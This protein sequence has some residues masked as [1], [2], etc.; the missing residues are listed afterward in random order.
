MSDRNLILEIDD[1]VQDNPRNM[2]VHTPGKGITM[3]ALPL[4]LLWLCLSTEPVVAAE[5]AS[6]F[7]VKPSVSQAGGKTTVSF[8]VSGPTDV[9]VAILDGKGAV[10]RHL[11]AGVLGGKEAPP[12][13]LTPG[14]AQ[15]LAWDGQDD[16]GQAAQGGPFSVRVRIGMGAK[17]D[18]IAGGDPYALWSDQSGQ[19]DHAQWRITGLDAKPDGSV[20]IFANNTPFGVPTLRKYDARGNYRSTVFPPPAGKPTEEV[21]GWGMNVRSDGTYTLRPNYGW[22]STVSQW[23]VMA[24]GKDGGDIWSGRLVPTPELDKLCI[25]SPPAVGNQRMLFSVDGTLR[26]FTPSV[27]LGGEPLPK[28]G[29]VLPYFTALTPDGKSLYVSGL[30]AIQ[31]GFWREGQ[32]WK[33]DIASRD[34]SVSF[35][36]GSDERKDRDAIGH[37]DACPYSAF[38]GVAVDGEGRLF[39]CDRMNKRIAVVGP[40]GKL[41][42][43]LPVANPDAVAVSPKSKAVYVTTRFGNYSGNGELKLLKFGDW[44]KD[45]APEVSM[46]LRNGI[47]KRQESSLLTVVVDKGEIMVW[48]AYT[49]L[50]ARVYKDTGTDLKLV[51]DFYEAGSQRAL[52][53]QH[54]TI[55]PR[56]GHAY[57][58]DSQGFLFRIRDWKKPVFD[59]CMLDEK[60][61]LNASSI[62][63]DARSRHLYTKHHYNKPVNRWAMD[64]E[65]FTPVPVG[66][67]NEIVPPITCSWVFTGLWE[68]GMAACPGGVATLGVVLLPGSRIDDYRGPLTY[69]RPDAAKAPWTGLTFANFGGKNPNSGGVQFDARGNLYVGLVDGKP[70]NVPQEFEKDKDYR[71]KIGRIHKYAPTGM[72]AGGDLFPNEPAAPAKVYDIH[73]GPIVHSPRFGVD[74]YGRIYYPNGL[75]PQVAV[76]DNEG[77]TILAFGTYGNRDSL[78]GLPGDQV[79]TKDVPMAWPNSVDATDDHI[80]VS[81][82]LN[83]RLMRLA[84]TFVAAET[85][86]IN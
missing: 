74:G 53:L 72:M 66:G 18:T 32:V 51:K 29:F 30:S 62:A 58:A 8:A 9:E 36:L 46:L 40:D 7:T 84:K 44:S 65:F 68:R 17:L 70:T 37:S 28:K 16:Y 49:Q 10:V 42:R 35:S 55:D 33:V 76:I 26:Q 57:I 13:P 22:G 25:V 79:P 6:S 15:S 24:G 85:V 69:F 39:V 48:V 2:S 31:D 60:T 19:G 73:Y 71:E 47:G 43:S 14:L 21:Q 41:I 78:G 38:Q 34:T 27:A 11:A 12:A 1:W 75:L 86:R 63:I 80:F 81:D 23:T 20:F 4:A 59:P 5:Q 61:R 50:P 82:M 54:M 56:T 67:S 64:G 83:V 77:N 3:R 45:M 52:D